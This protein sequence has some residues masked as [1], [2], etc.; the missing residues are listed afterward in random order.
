MKRSKYN[1]SGRHIGSCDMGELIPVGWRACLPGDTLRI[2]QNALIRVSPLLAPVMSKVTV[3]LHNFFIP[4]RLMWPNFEKYITGG[5]DG[6]DATAHPYITT[7]NDTG[8]GEGS[9]GDY[10][11]LMPGVPNVQV[12]A[13]PFRAFNMV[14]NEYYRDQD[15]DPTG[16]VVSTGDGSDTTTNITTNPMRVAWKKDYFTLCRPYAQKGTEISMPLPQFPSG[17]PVTGTALAQSAGDGIPRLDYGTNTDRAFTSENGTNELNLSGANA[18]SSSQGAWNDPKLEVEA[19]NNYSGVFAVSDV[20]TISDLRTAFALQRYKENRSRFGSR[21]TEYL[22]FLGVRAQDARLQRPEYMGGGKAVVQFS[23]VMQVSPDIDTGSSED[24]GVA[25]MKGHGIAHTRT[26]GINYFVPEHGIWMSFMSIIPD[27]IYQNSIDKEW[28]DIQSK[29]QYWQK[30]LEHIG[31]EEVKNIEV[32]MSHNEPNG[33]FGW[34]NRYEKYRNGRSQISGEMRSSLDFW[35]LARNEDGNPALN[36]SFVQCTPRKDIHS[37]ES[38]DAI[39]FLVNNKIGARRLV[40][41]NT[42]SYVR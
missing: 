39:W 2:R 34:N 22:Q 8:F 29:E 24:F 19:D 7:P 3:R 31:Q 6:N 18:T 13:L 20:P 16:R 1:L 11:G 33:T 35:H 30:E 25:E 42:Q 40:S 28:I 37:V 41:R 14:Y 9:L 27:A 10:L 12:N 15:L 5:P 17:I 4:N 36:L 38:R 32:K 23:E 26:P 21:F